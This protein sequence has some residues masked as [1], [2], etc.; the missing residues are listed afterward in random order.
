MKSEFVRVS[1]VNTGTRWVMVES[2][3]GYFELDVE[4]ESF[5]NGGP[6]DLELIE[7][8]GRW[9]EL[10]RPWSLP[11]LVFQARHA[12]LFEELT[13]GHSR[14]VAI[15]IVNPDATRDIPELRAYACLTRIEELS[16]ENAYLEEQ[17][18]TLARFESVECQGVVPVVPDES[19]T[20]FR[21]EGVSM[22]LRRDICLRLQKAG[23][24]KT[25]FG[26]V[27]KKSAAVQ[28]HSL[29]TLMKSR[30]GEEW[31]RQYVQRMRDERGP[32]DA[33]WL[34]ERWDALKRGESSKA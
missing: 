12:Q 7:P 4:S 17:Y 9:P 8:G 19:L 2:V 26:E 21:G 24:H 27:Y 32:E 13:A 15:R 29:Q 22:W 30:G 3:H 28:S 6:I 25:Q 20:C 31:F 16:F 5:R 33:A 10:F 34:E 14:E 23:V 1:N 18:R 11:L